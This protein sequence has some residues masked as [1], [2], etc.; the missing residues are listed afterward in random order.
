[1]LKPLSNLPYKPGGVGVVPF[2]QTHAGGYQGYSGYRPGGQQ[3]PH[4]YQG[5]YAPREEEDPNITPVEFML[6]QMRDP[7]LSLETRMD[8]AKSAA[9]YVHAKLA[10]LP[11]QG[12][13][14]KIKIEITGGLPPPSSPGAQTTNNS[15][16]SPPSESSTVTVKVG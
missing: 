10:A 5:R 12:D 11:V 8:A 7:N 15:R 6:K 4:G 1:M 3:G 2:G 13:G 9:P 16:Q 14:N